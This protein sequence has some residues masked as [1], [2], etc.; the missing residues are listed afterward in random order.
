MLAIKVNVWT[1]VLALLAV[2]GWV[3]I[4]L[5]NGPSDG[6]LLPVNCRGSTVPGTMEARWTFDQI[7]D[8]VSPDSSG[9]GLE[10]NSRAARR[11]PPEST[12][13]P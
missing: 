6:N 3:A 13:M 2:I 9:S 7:R 5:L 10:A 11:S 12:A 4:L 8:G 1:A